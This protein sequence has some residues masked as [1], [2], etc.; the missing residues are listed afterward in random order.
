MLP[1][2]NHIMEKFGMQVP[3]VHPKHPS[4]LSPKKGVLIEKGIVPIVQGTKEVIVPRVNIG[5]G[6]NCLQIG[7]FH[8]NALDFSIYGSQPRRFPLSEIVLSKGDEM[9]EGL[10][11]GRRRGNNSGI[12]YTTMTT[13]V[14]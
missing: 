10:H 1:S 3:L 5:S 6:F 7:N 11:R 9:G 4:S 2:A 8:I 14:V 13:L 12:S